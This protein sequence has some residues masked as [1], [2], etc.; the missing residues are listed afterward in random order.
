MSLRVLMAVL[1][2]LMEDIYSQVMAL[3]D[4]QKRSRRSQPSF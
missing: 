2:S 3:L 1:H 4:Q